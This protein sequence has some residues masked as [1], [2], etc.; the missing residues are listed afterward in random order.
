MPIVSYYKIKIP[1]N[2]YNYVLK[3]DLEIH[4]N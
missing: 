3:N 2:Y 1:N 4:H